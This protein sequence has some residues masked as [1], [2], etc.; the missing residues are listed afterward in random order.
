MTICHRWWDY[1][2][3]FRFLLFFFLLF[4][5]VSRR[6][7]RRLRKPEIIIFHFQA[8]LQLRVLTHLSLLTLARSSEAG[9]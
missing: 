3:S 5:Y 2:G 8:I 7:R 1:A 4:Q 6:R 9:G